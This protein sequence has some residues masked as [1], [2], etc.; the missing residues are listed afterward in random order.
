M[1]E[2]ATGP[3]TGLLGKCLFGIVPSMY[4]L[5]KQALCHALRRHKKATAAAG[6]REFAR[7]RRTQ[8]LRTLGRSCGLIEREHTIIDE[9]HIVVSHGE[10]DE[11]RLGDL[12][13]DGEE[14]VGV[15]HGD[16]VDVSSRGRE[17]LL[18]C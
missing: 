17:P 6:F 4:M 10:R 7:Y 13:L 11:D 5:G 18:Y 16:V 8:N 3:R 14:R 12:T 9:P 1:A 2:V 15:D